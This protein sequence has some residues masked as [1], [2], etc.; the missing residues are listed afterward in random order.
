[1]TALKNPWIRTPILIVL[2]FTIGFSFELGIKTITGLA[3]FFILIIYLMFYF[4][5]DLE[6]QFNKEA[7]Q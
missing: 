1:M 6:K 3:A 2:G 5:K 4:D 7:L